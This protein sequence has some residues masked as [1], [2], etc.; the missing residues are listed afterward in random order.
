MHSKF[1]LNMSKNFTVHWLCREVVESLSLTGDIQETTEWN[2][3]LCALGWLCLSREVDQMARYGPS[4]PYPFYD[5][6]IPKD[7]NWVICHFVSSAVVK[8]QSDVKFTRNPLSFCKLKI[9]TSVLN[10]FWRFLR[11][12]IVKSSDLEMHLEEVLS[13][14]RLSTPEA[15]WQL[16]SEGGNSPKD[17]IVG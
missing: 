3:V 13:N 16:K 8:D 12:L 4:Q 1:Y 17:R 7:Y 5:S 10:I 11:S 14:H 9:F 2:P 15:Q 6:V